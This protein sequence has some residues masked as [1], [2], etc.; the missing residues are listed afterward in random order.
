MRETAP[1]LK[2][3]TYNGISALEIPYKVPEISLLILVP[4]NAAKNNIHTFIPGTETYKEILSRM[5]RKRVRMEIPKFKVESSFSLADILIEMGMPSLF[6]NADLSGI[7]GENDLV[8]DEVLQKVFFE[9]DEN[10][11]EA[12]AATAVLIKA[13]SAAPM[14]QDPP[15]LFKA[16]RPFIFILKENTFNTPLFTGYIVNP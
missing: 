9:I 15:V 13:T 7:S 3:V 11:T 4:E 5:T 2:H 14:P 1:G 16:D 10:G 12:A 8:V 6:S